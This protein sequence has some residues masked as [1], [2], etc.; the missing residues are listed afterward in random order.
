MQ[1]GDLILNT[2]PTSGCEGMVG[3]I[4][5]VSVTLKGA[6]IQLFKV[7]SEGK[8]MLWIAT[9]CEVIDECR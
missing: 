3:I 1:V 6:H 5:E 7:L 9:D 8:E 4:I 2:H